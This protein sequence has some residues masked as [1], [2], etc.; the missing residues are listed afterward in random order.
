MRLAFCFSWKVTCFGRVIGVSIGRW[1]SVLPRRTSQVCRVNSLCVGS[2]VHTAMSHAPPGEGSTQILSSK[3]AAALVHLFCPCVSL[4]SLHG[5]CDVWFA[6]V[7][8]CLGLV[9]SPSHTK[10]ASCFVS[11]LSPVTRTISWCIR[12]PMSCR[13]AVEHEIMS[14]HFRFAI[15]RGMQ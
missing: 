12:N 2:C 11:L 8:V 13:C 4:V 3:L 15:A 5:F 1:L 6:C 9:R 7:Q 10:T 14:V